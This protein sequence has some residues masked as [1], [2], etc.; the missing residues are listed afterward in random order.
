MIMMGSAGFE[1]FSPPLFEEAI[2][3]YA[4]SICEYI[5]QQ[6]GISLY[7]M[8]G[9][10]LDV[11]RMGF[12]NQIRMDVYETFSPPPCGIVKDLTEARGYLQPEICSMG[13]LPVETLL[14]GSDSEIILEAQKLSRLSQD[15]K[16]IVGIADTVIAG[17][18]PESIRTFVNAARNA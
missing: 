18:T 7:H 1:L 6:G 4:Q 5:R 8:C 15:W 11:A 3:P 9:H 14:T 12:F 2:V 10:S 17:T 16:H 13:N